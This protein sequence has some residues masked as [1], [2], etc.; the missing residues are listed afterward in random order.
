MLIQHKIQA[1]FTV[2]L[3]SLLLA[4]VSAWW[5]EQRNV[6]LF[7]RVDHTR[8]V[9]DRLDG[10]L[11]DILNTE[12][13]SR[14][15][16][17]SGDAAFLRPYEAGVTAV[18]ESFAAVQRLT[19]DNP[20]QQR[21]L[22]TLAP[23]IRDKLNLANEVIQLRRGGDADGAL[24]R[25]SSGEGVQ[26][27]DEIRQLIAAM[28]AEQSQLLQER[29]AQAQA[30]ARMTMALVAFGAVLSLGMIGLASFIVKRDFEVRQQAEVERDLFFTVPLDLLC[31]ISADGYLKRVNP[32]FT[33]I[34][35]WSARDLTTRPYLEFVHPDDRAA[36]QAEVKRQLA[37]GEG[38][39]QFENRCLH[40]D[41]SSRV[42]W[43]KTVLQP[44]GL[45]FATAR[46]VTEQKADAELLRL[47]EEKLAVTLNSIGDAVLATDAKR[48]VTRLNPIAERLTGWTHAEAL[49][50]PVEEVFHIINEETRAPAVIPVDEVLATGEIH[51]LANH[52]MII[53]RDGTELP[54]A[55]SAAP[56]RDLA[57]RIIGVVLVFRDVRS[58]HAAQ[59]ALRDSDALNRAVLNSMMANIAVVD[60]HGTIIAINDGWERFARE[61]GADNMMSK[62]G[63]GVNY[64][65]V[66]ERAAQTLGEE[67]Q[68]ILDGLRGVLAH[69]KMTFKHEYPCHSPTQYR[70]FTMHV[71]PL[72]REEGGAVIAQINITERK[73]AEQ[74]LADFK[75]ALD[76]HAI[77]AV[78]DAKGVITYVNDKFCAI[79]KYAREELLGQDHGIINSGYHSKSM[80]R[81]LW[82]TITSGRVWKGEIRNRAKDGTFYWVDTTIVPFLGEDGRPA[83]Y[84]AIR[85]DITDRRQMEEVLRENGRLLSESQRIAHIGGWSWDMKGVIHWTD[86]TYRIYGV[87]PETFTPTIE[88][89][90]N[91]VHP[92]DRSEM[93]RWL[94]ACSAGEKPGDLEFRAV[95]PDG[96]V[97]WLMGCGELICNTEGSSRCMTGIV[98]D[99]TE[100]KRAEEEIRQFNTELEQ[101]VIQRTGALKEKEAQLR[102]A[103]RIGQ[104]GSWHFEVLTN[105][106]TWSDEIFRIFEQDPHQ[107]QA[108][109][110]AFMATVHPDDR[111][112]IDRAYKESVSNHTPYEVEH[113]LQ[114]RD[115]RIKFVQERG[116]TVYDAAGQA[117]HSLGTV[118]DITERKLAEERDAA[119][120]RKLQRLSELGMQLSGEPGA[121]FEEVV[122]MV[123][124][125]FEV[126]VVCLS[127]IVG[128]ELQFKAVHANGQVFR[129]AGGCPLAITPCATVEVT[130]DL[131]TYERVQEH[132]PQAAFLR[133]HNAVAY[134]GVP[135]L[136]AQGGVVAITCL[137]DSK[138]REFSEE[139]L[140]ILR[141]IA[142]RVAM[143]LERAH[144]LAE[145]NNMERLALRSQ[146]MEAIGTLSGGV[147]HDLNNALAPIMMGVDLLRR[148]YPGESQIV[149]MFEASA[150]RGADMV[151]QLL[152]FAKGAE[153]ERVVIRVERLIKELESLM[154]S[155]FP[156]NIR[157][158]VKCEPELP[159]VLGDAT[160]LHQILLNL[161]V[162]ARDAMPRGGT[163]TLEARRAEVDA[164]FASSVP[165]ARPG[166]YLAL[167]VQDTGSGIPR[168]IIDRIFDPF[169][170][171]KDPD[172]GTGLGLSTVMGLVKSHGGFLQVS[173]PPE[174]GSVFVA[175]LPV[176]EAGSGLA[177]KVKET[178]ECR[179][180]GETILVVDD[181]APVREMARRVLERLNFQP[182]TATDGVDGLLVASQQ[183]TSLR[184]VITDL[185]MPHMDGLTFVRVLRRMLPDIPI[186]IASGRLDDAQAREFKALG[187]VSMLD[188][189]FSEGQLAEALKKI[190]APT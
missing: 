148:R 131:R 178:V 26:M 132:F 101:L 3:L 92:D 89:L 158:A 141:I 84:I 9:I 157:L 71:S 77:V 185:H 114:M 10:T 162:N 126:P 180:Q 50:R 147:A 163:L 57:G 100:R 120:L 124:T 179:G 164:A 48:R 12:T 90:I 160:Q 1:G 122:S 18:Q 8:E 76:E 155:S 181:E 121:V 111:S 113:R 93:Q 119:H 136:N 81:G 59:R 30:M 189:P 99:I 106:L 70:W 129:D 20:G 78:T 24:Q 37:V 107:F 67:A 45:M 96:S 98:Q 28:K 128:Q 103:Q 75:A 108:S 74:V 23:M 41:G 46:D 62:V 33:Q 55:D 17:I 38:V 15:F 186:V 34:L 184:A 16:A 36:T 82:E 188:K 125:L 165:D 79:S 138:P 176:N 80:I 64:L 167:R 182:L 143:E 151:R 137:L 31:I 51:G 187:A 94:G 47:R 91:L 13:G 7:G 63:V 105:R 161:C 14:G 4:G 42:F 2:A 127:E 61:N 87:P 104:I 140:E 49:G 123:A 145:R 116:E 142:Q 110:E 97:R 58:E 112:M 27:M 109:Y 86:E 19:E 190:L 134:C 177:A 149:D 115:G 183:K 156:K 85:A 52:T 171:T 60:R 32:A 133:D 43:W 146:R 130:K 153:G 29:A 22:A 54:I 152:T 66:C 83:Q 39:L 53:A 56:I 68:E 102:E 159:T 166:Q 11:V 25:I 135:S 21:R 73:R 139:D 65:E 35:G 169:F 5:S 88:S 150:K 69:S 117:L 44:E 172:K 175:Y 40:K 170:T 72:S 168:E 173:S 174:G 6:Q 95:R 144:N 154:M 118:Q